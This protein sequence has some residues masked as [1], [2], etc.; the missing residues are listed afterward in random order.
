M[1]EIISF[2]VKR[3]YKGFIRPEENIIFVFGSNPEGRHGLGTAKIARE[4]FGA[5][6]GQGEGLQGNSYALPTKDLRI[7]K[8]NALR[9]ITPQQIQKSIEKLI[10]VAN[11]HPEKL[12]CVAYTNTSKPSLNGY[13]G[14]EMADMFIAAFNSVGMPVNQNIVFSENWKDYFVTPIHILEDWWRHNGL[15][16]RERASGLPRNDDYLNT[17]DE[18]WYQLSHEEKD[19][20]YTEYFS[21]I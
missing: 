11:A 14:Q 16:A 12:F 7:K 6:Y 10:S 4:Q 21:E 5:I 2:N 15:C 3:F 20:V 13:T 18:W 19:A 9:S 1:N 8:N 17:T